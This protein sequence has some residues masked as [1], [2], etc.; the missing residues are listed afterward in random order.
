M[1]VI[2]ANVSL[3]KHPHSGVRGGSEN[4]GPALPSGA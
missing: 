3:V 1:D 4:S 2:A